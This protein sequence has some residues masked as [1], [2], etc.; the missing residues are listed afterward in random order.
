[1]LS[2]LSEILP[3]KHEILPGK[4]QYQEVPCG[5]ITEKLPAVRAAFWLDLMA[6]FLCYSE[7]SDHRRCIDA[8]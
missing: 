3:G 6:V 2:A 7:L 8:F 5:R 4:H 1:M